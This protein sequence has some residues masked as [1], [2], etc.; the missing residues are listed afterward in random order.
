MAS[1]D[2]KKVKTP[3]EIKAIM[4]HNSKDTRSR[5]KEHSNTDIDKSKTAQNYSLDGLSYAERC[6]R[7]DE[8]IAELDRTTNTNK[9]KDRVT[10]ICLEYPVPKDLPPERYSEW[11]AVAHQLIVD[12][13]GA[14]NVVCSDCHEDEVHDY[15]HS[16]SG[17]T[18][19]SRVHFHEIV[20]PVD[21]SGKL[22]AKAVESK[23][24]MIELNNAIEAKTQELFGVRFM[25]GE[26]RKG[27]SVEGVK[28]RS[29]AAVEK[30]ARANRKQSKDLQEAA[31]MLAN[32]ATQQNERETLQNEREAALNEREVLLHQR[33]TEGLQRLSE[34][35]ESVSAARRAYEQAKQQAE[36]PDGELVRFCKRKGYMQEFEREQAEKKRLLEEQEAHTR[37]IAAMYARFGRGIKATEDAPAPT[38]QQEDENQKSG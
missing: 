12:R 10:A 34:G 36:A 13:F 16:I 26:K 8:R 14:E 21:K 29:A 38:Q 3:N 35:L 18:V 11:F 25:T 28:E 6:R 24:S 4:F 15:K 17:E 20:I 23:Q 30:Q 27:L 1:V 2:W 33:E 31:S 19:V 9:R 5:T 32:R 22:N 7:Y 37:R